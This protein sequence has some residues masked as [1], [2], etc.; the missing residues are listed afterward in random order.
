MMDSDMITAPAS[1]IDLLNKALAYFPNNI[2]FQI[3][4][5]TPSGE[6]L[7][8]WTSITYREFIDDVHRYAKYWSNVL[9]LEGI[10]SRE[11]VVL[12]CV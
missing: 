12:W 6:T 1:P 10:Y 3:P 5:Y 7:E 4:K 9:S 2:A 8:E 11:V